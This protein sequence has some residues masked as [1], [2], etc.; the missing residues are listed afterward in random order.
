MAEIEEGQT[1]RLTT[2][3]GH[4]FVAKDGKT[5]NNQKTLKTNNFCFQ[6]SNNIDTTRS[7]FDGGHKDS[8]HNQSSKW[9]RV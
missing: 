6:N 4:I 7:I 9:C 5:T 2:F 3:A 1:F 8:N